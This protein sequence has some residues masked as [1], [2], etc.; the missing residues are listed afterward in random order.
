[1]VNRMTKRSS[2]TLRA[3]PLAALAV[4]VALTGF[5]D[6]AYAQ[7]AAPNAGGAQQACRAD[8]ERLCSG[9]QPGGGRVVVCLKQNASRLSPDCAAAL[10]VAQN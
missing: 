10:S 2:I 8:F 1:M 3:R 4:A 9:V 6:V 7:G 5:G